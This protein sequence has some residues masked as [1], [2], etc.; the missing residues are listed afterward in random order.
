MKRA[1]FLAILALS[2][3]TLSCSS[4]QPGSEA[5]AEPVNVIRSALLD[6]RSLYT[7]GGD[8]YGQLG[9]GTPTADIGI[10]ASIGIADARQVACAQSYHSLVLTNN[11]TVFGFGQNTY[12]QVKPGAS[13]FTT[14]Q[15]I[16]LGSDPAIAIATG[17]FHSL[18]LLSTHRVLAWGRN[19]LAQCGFS[20]PGGAN[21]TTPTDVGLSNIVAIAAGAYH[22]LALDTQGR[23][24]AWGDNS[25]GELGLGHVNAVTSPQV[26][27]LDN[28][29]SISAGYRFSLVR[30]TQADSSGHVVDSVWAFGENVWGNFGVPGDNNAHPT[31]AQIP[32]LTG[33]KEV[34]AG[35]FHATAVKN[36]GSLLTWGRND[37]GQLG[38]SGGS[39]PAIRQVT[40]P[41]IQHARAG[42]THTMA[43][44][45]DGDLWSWGTNTNLQVGDGTNI[46]RLSPVQITA[47]S[48]VVSL[49]TCSTWSMAIVGAS[50]TTGTECASGFCADGVCC[51]GPCT[52]LCEACAEPDHVGQCIPVSGAAAV[53]NSLVEVE[54]PVDQEIDSLALYETQSHVGSVRELES[55]PVAAICSATATVTTNKSEYAPFERIDVAYANVPTS[56]DT[57]FGLAPLG[58][59]HT[60]VTT[61]RWGEGSAS[62]TFQLESPAAGTYV[63]RVMQN[64]YIFVA[65]SAPFTVGALAPAMV[66]A[67]AT[68]DGGTNFHVTFA[69]FPATTADWIAIATP[70]AAPST[71]S[72]WLYTPG[73]ASGT[74]TFS[75]PTAPGA[76]EVRGFFNSL[77][78]LTR[79]VIQASDTFTVR[80][81]IERVSVSSTGAEGNAAGSF[82]SM[83]GSLSTNDG[84]YVAFAS[85]S[86]NLVAND[87]NGAFS[88][89]FRR[90]LSTGVTTRVN[91][92]PGGVQTDGGS[93]KPTIS[94]DGYY[95]AFNSRA[96]NLTAI[97][98]P[99]FN[100]DVFLNDVHTGTTELISVS[101][102]GGPGN[103][104]STYPS[105]SD[106]GR[107]VVF[108]SDASNLVAGDTNANSDIFLRDRALGTTVR[109]SVN[110]SG[111]QANGMSRLARISGNGAYVVFMSNA[112]GLVAS[113]TTSFLDVFVR[114]MATGITER[115]SVATSGQPNADSS[116][117]PEI[118]P[119]GQFVIFRSAATN[120]IAADT[121]NQIDLFVRD[122]IANVT[123]RVNVATNG[124]QAN[125][126]VDTEGYAISANG[127]IAVFS[128]DA[129]N[130][131]SGDTN[132]VGDVFK[133]DLSTS[134]TT[135]ISVDV[136]GAQANGR[137]W[138]TLMSP[139][140]LRV[141]FE[142]AATNL[143][144]NDTNGRSDVFVRRLF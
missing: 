39:G 91:L 40:L 22:N 121:N 35:G 4:E 80:G 36:D 77:A 12:S 73:T 89:I 96:T 88:D 133:R 20:T 144:P 13:Q 49:D 21:V 61:F 37:F 94:C 138:R 72:A 99:T 103:G 18:A 7:W 46:H 69:G 81:L 67:P 11:G 105:V 112:P 29:A 82:G 76:Y 24:F 57:W 50:C 114:S 74:L 8:A 111:Q 23:L 63:V 51:N 10:P 59:P 130:L 120:L 60:T 86:S 71:Y 137:S 134:T 65:E 132:A 66:E 106:D 28:V 102:T 6:T 87:T 107:F 54:N 119:T 90:N 108:S 19:H 124:T 38:V 126:A 9:N 117:L 33:V 104:E 32:G 48:H 55:E 131:V 45:T 2:L 31:P 16:S 3:P 140:G 128:S 52:A 101:T 1:L 83:F 62:G 15:Q 116:G 42:H 139:D 109:V 17:G 44:T 118:S 84:E 27:N 56:L 127:K 142:S 115:V 79:Y 5:P 53:V 92:G 135:R 75:A 25:H 122:R 34:T 68:V 143:V 41:P 47:L 113:K 141:V 85:D 95:V 64:P 14:P 110:P 136:A 97:S 30:R 58:S 123:T 78:P 100:N 70:G 26:V 43:I 129:S 125:A 98:D 93:D